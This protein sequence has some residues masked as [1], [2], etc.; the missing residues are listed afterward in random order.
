MPYLPKRLCRYPGCNRIALGNGY[1]EKHKDKAPVYKHDPITHGMYGH[2]WQRESH[3]F[4]AS[5]PWCEDCLGRG[6]YTP[7]TEVHH[8]VKH[9][10][11]A[12]LF[13]NRDNWMGLCKSCHSTRTARGE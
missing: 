1:C 6:I 2:K 11:D 4:L 10:G 3:K 8:K 13:W 5:H 12:R 9:K 7:A